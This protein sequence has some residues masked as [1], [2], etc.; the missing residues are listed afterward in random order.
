[1][2]F[3]LFI[4]G[5]PRPQGSKLAYGSGT[6][7]VESSPHVKPWRADIR[8]HVL[9]ERPE[10]WP[11]DEPVTLR[12]QFRFQRPKNHLSARGGL[13]P[14]APYYHVLRTGDVDKLARA[15]LDAL[16]SVLFADDAQVVCLVVTKA[17]ADPGEPEGMR[18]A[19]RCRLSPPD[20]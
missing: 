4:P 14:S 13:V 12:L 18:L 6:R 19:A 17:Y 11:L 2:Q 9:A 7:M 20:D 16:T 8:H 1:M 3:S 10:G 5:R 15:A